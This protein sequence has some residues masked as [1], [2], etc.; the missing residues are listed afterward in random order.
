MATSG[1]ST[2]LVENA[3]GMKTYLEFSWTLDS[4]NIAGNYSQISWQ[5]RF[6][7]ED[8]GW[9]GYIGE[10][11]YRVNIEDA[12][13]TGASSVAIGI[14]GSKVLATG[15][16]TIQH[17]ND[18]SKTF[19][20]AYTVEFGDA[21]LGTVTGTGTGELPDIPRKARIVTAPNFTDEETPII[22]YDNPAGEE[23]TTLQ[24]CIAN[25]IGTIIYAPY[26]DIDKSG[27]SYRFVLT[28]EE[29]AALYSAAGNVNTSLSIRFYVR[30]GMGDELNY[31]H[32]NK[33]FT[34]KPV[35]PTL[36]FEILEDVSESATRVTGDNQTIV[37]GHSD[38]HY[39]VLAAPQKGATITKYSVTNGNSTK[40]VDEGYF[41]NTRNGVFVATVEDSRGYTTTISQELSVI[42]YFPVTCNQEVVLNMDGTLDVTITGKYWNDSFG[43]FDNRL[44]V[45]QR[46]RKD[47]GTWSSWN[48]LD[49]FISEMSGGTYTLNA[50]LSDFDPNGT[51]E[52]QSRATDELGT[53][54]SGI[55][56][57]TLLPIFDWSR[58]D[59]NF[60]V[61]VTIEGAPLNDYVIQTGTESMGTNGTW[62]WCKWKSGK[63]EAW[64]CQNFG[65]MAITTAWGGLYRS[66]V[67]EQLIPG[68]FLFTPDVIDISLRDSDFGGW[69][70]KHESIPPN[71]QSV[72]FMVVRPASATTSYTNI[73]FHLIGR[74]K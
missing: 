64:G 3:L 66:S 29:L 63:A 44:S 48:T 16:A 54:E 31:S 11:N 68:C 15:T 26:R 19:W 1:I 18:G 32:L 24:A 25:S 60:N 45:Q 20:Y 53:A 33:T 55:Q 37:A 30:S 47:G 21:I 10:R 57:V 49:M 73:S 14:N 59:F 56:S 52:F 36:E 71:A 27:S 43:E 5:L 58:N 17:I 51:Y 61:P 23:I 12:F 41:N 4:Q 65:K 74:W 9:N 69:V 46:N 13:Y 72:S 35:K 28:D 62:R 38:I 40:K 39:K 8:G 50:T 34:I 42:N 6:Y 22:I 7:G 67:F 2:T 70:C